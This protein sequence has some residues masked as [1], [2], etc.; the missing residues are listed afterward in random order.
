MRGGLIRLEIYVL[1]GF[2]EVTVWLS[3]APLKMEAALGYVSLLLKGFSVTLRH[4]VLDEHRPG[5]AY[6]T[7]CLLEAF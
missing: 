4:L 2:W 3:R 1:R 6:G 5:N 7:T